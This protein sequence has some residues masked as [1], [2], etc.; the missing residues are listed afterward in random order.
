MLLLSSRRAYNVDDH[1]VSPGTTILCLPN[2]VLLEIFD[3]F[4]QIFQHEHRYEKIWNINKGWF[5]LAHVCQE[6]RQVILTLPSRLCIR[7]PHHS[8]QIWKIDCEFAIRHLPP[9]PIVVDLTPNAGSRPVKVQHRLISALAYPDR[10]PVEWG[11][12]M[13]AT[14]IVPIR[15]AALLSCHTSGEGEEGYV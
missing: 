6:W 15:V 9:L 7:L 13:Y 2:E 11:V 14:S 3:S 10:V 8:V 5:K 4:R 1:H 12:S